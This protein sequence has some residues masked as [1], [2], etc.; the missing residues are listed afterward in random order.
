LESLLLLNVLDP[1]LDRFWAL[2]TYSRSVFDADFDG[3]DP[4]RTIGVHDGG[5]VRTIEVAGGSGPGARFVSEV[6]GTPGEQR[7]TS[8][9]APGGFRMS[10][11]VLETSVE[12]AP[13][14]PPAAP[15]LS[16]APS[17]VAELYAMLA[18]EVDGGGRRAPGFAEALY[19]TRLLDV[20][21]RAAD[22]GC[23]QRLGWCSINYDPMVMADGIEATNE[24]C[25]AFA[26]RPTGSRTIR[27]SR[28]SSGGS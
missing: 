10:D 24:P 3:V 22:T 2:S 7:L 9:A 23:R 8:S 14:D 12:C 15:V 11:V 6:V 18:A 13:P 4:V 27:G 25:C 16:G 20:V 26:L 28:D 1:L 17:N 5:C 19:L 21:E